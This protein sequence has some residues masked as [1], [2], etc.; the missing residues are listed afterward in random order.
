MQV[1]NAEIFAVE[2]FFA[3]QFPLQITVVALRTLLRFESLIW[4]PIRVIISHLC[5][6]FLIAA[7]TNA[8]CIKNLIRILPFVVYLR[9]FDQGNMD[10]RPS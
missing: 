6:H 9:D 10:V 2:H 5:D 4:F 3:R 8:G 1:S 7:K